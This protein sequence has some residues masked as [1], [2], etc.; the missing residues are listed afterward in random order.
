MATILHL[1]TLYRQGVP[2][3]DD[4]PIVVFKEDYNELPILP[5]L[6]VDSNWV[7]EKDVFV[8]SYRNHRNDAK[9]NHPAVKLFNPNDEKQ[10]IEDGYDLVDNQKYWYFVWIETE[11]CWICFQY[12]D[13][14]DI[15]EAYMSTVETRD[16]R[17]GEIYRPSGEA[18][19]IIK[20]FYKA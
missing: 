17:H 6:H 11:N 4:D 7:I 9:A 19:A 8:E 2:D 20:H 16:P 3:G 5:N 13:M 14:T 15:G 1:N 10:K 18:M 12:W